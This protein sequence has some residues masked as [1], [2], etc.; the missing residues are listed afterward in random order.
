MPTAP[1]MPTLAPQAAFRR[2][3]LHN[4]V[5]K[6]GCFRHQLCPS[7]LL[8]HMTTRAG[9]PPQSH[10]TSAPVRARNTR[11]TNNLITRA[12]RLR[13]SCSMWAL[14]AVGA[15]VAGR[16]VVAAGGRLRLESAAGFGSLLLESIPD[17]HLSV[18]ISRLAR[19]V[20]SL[21]LNDVSTT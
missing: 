17:S 13:A 18:C 14:V 5:R 11:Q 21:H 7:R 10:T 3:H 6:C 19:V 16:Q 1:T 2:T 8:W 15:V 20:H 12:I 4:S 9:A